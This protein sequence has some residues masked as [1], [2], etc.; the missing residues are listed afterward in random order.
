MSEATIYVHIDDREVVK[1]LKQLEETG[2]DMSSV[3]RQIAGIMADAVEENFKQQGRPDRWKALKPAT[4]KQ[5][6]RE[7][8]YPK[9]TPI[10][11][12]SGQLMRSITSTSDST[13]ASVGTIKAYAAIQQFG[14]MAGRGKRVRIPPRP[15]LALD[16]DDLKEIMG[17]I[18]TALK[19]D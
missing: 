15:F 8:T 1:L 5:R 4:I 10:L 13:T 6:M 3:M 11:E 16:E 19:V 17:V 2:K 9:D 18:T 12:R 7:G 14:G